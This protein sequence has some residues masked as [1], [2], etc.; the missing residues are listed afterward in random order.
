MKRKNLAILR[1]PEHGTH[2]PGK[3]P[4]GLHTEV[5]E[6]PVQN[7]RCVQIFHGFSI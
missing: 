3:T 1:T 2:I 7:L 5:H 6:P 4:Y